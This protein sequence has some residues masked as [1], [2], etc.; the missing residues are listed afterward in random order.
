MIIDEPQTVLGKEAKNATRK[1]LKHFNPL[2][3]LLYS[4]THRE[5][6]NMVY[7]LDAIDAYNKKLV[8]KIEV[9]GIHQVGS[10]ATNGYIYLDEIVVQIGKN[11]Q[12][13]LSFDTLGRDGTM[14]R[15]TKLVG[16][17]FDLYEQSGKLAEYEQN[18][19]VDKIDGGAGTVTFLNKLELHEGD[20]AVTLSV[21]A[22]FIPGV[23]RC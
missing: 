16:E 23:S 8:K 15:Q 9:K 14:R 1:G 7:R 4:A 17:G 11:P 22:T 19:V 5:V 13:R 20:V 21:N 6:L 10:T 3:T 2:F 18:Y 12:A